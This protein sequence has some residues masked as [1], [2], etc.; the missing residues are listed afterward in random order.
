MMQ[1]FT[2]FQLFGTI[3]VGVTTGNDKYFSI[4]KEVCEKYKLKETTLP[5]VGKNSHI[6]GAYF[7]KSDW[8]KNVKRGE[9][10]K[11]ITFPSKPLAKYPKEHQEY[12]EF[13]E[14]NKVHRGYKC[15]I[16]EQWYVVPSVWIPDAFFPKFNYLYPK[17]AINKCEAISI[18]SVNRIKLNDDI[19]TDTLLFHIIIVFRLFLL[20]FMEEVMER[21]FY[22]FLLEK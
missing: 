16:R 11:L 22:H 19:D 14:K 12:V 20:K 8:E 7:T 9:R 2:F 10:A 15:F 6:Y 13:G 1:N 5:L 17:L 3:N 21:E 4:D 18:S